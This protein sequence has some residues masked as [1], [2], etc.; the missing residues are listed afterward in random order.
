MFT[1]NEIRLCKPG[2]SKSIASYRHSRPIGPVEYALSAGGKRLRP[3]LCLLGYN[4]FLT[5]CRLPYCIRP[6]V[7]KCTTISRWYTTM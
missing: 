4:V 1:V 5:I 3:M 7:L 6:S 2:Y